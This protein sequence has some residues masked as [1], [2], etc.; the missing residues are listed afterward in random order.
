MC[1][2]TSQNDV[3]PKEDCRLSVGKSCMKCQEPATVVARLHDPFCR[4]CFLVYFTHRFRA[5]FGKS[6]AVRNGEKVLIAFSGGHSSCTMLHLVKEGLAEGV[7]KKLRYQP[8]VVYVDENVCLEQDKEERS[9]QMRKIET[10]LKESTFPSYVTCIEEVMSKCSPG[11]RL[12]S[13]DQS[14]DSEDGHDN[15]PTENSMKEEFKQLL[16]N[17]SSLTTKEDLIQKLRLKLLKQIAKQLG[18]TKIMFGDSG[19]RLATVLLGNLAKGHGETVHQ[20]MSFLD[21]RG[22]EVAIIRPMREFTS[23]EIA[24]FSHQ[25]C[26]QPVFIPRISTKASRLAS[27]DTLTEDFVNGLQSNFPAT[28]TTVL[29]TG[30]KLTSD[31]ETIGKRHTCVLCQSPVDS[32]SSASSASAATQYSMSLRKSSTVYSSSSSEP[33]AACEVA[34]DNAS[35]CGEG[36][37]SCQSAKKN[38]ELT[39]ADLSV[40]MCY[41][42][43]VMMRDVKSLDRLPSS[44]LAD[45][46]RQKRRDEM[47]LE[48]EDFLLDGS[49]EG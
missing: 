46:Q 47:R 35:C 28:V 31:E 39:S 18:Y 14:H 5:T 24:L 23:K 49:E 19:T 1:Q 36:D 12:I 6:K 2:I 30:A 40:V 22:E 33:E 25:C 37:E 38:E 20:D 29:K 26:L 9:A 13:G 4:N 10:W 15:P 16:E 21:T 27:I 43:Q 45:V 11:Y 32:S 42:C 8:G 7:H 48:I 17:T 3:I 41:G 44:V 34:R